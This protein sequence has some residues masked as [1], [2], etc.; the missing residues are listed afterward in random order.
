MRRWFRNLSALVAAG[1]VCVSVAMAATT[2]AATAKSSKAPVDV[3]AFDDAGGVGA[4]TTEWYGAEVAVDQLN[5]SGGWAGHKIVLK[6]CSTEAE[7]N[8]AS[9][10]AQ[11]A[12]A[13]KSSI[14]VIGS[15]ILSS[16]TD[17]I[18]QAAKLPMVGS[19]YI[20]EQDGASPISFPL[21]PS[22][23]GASGALDPFYKAGH[24]SITLVAG[25][26]GQASTEFVAGTNAIMQIGTGQQLAG[27]VLI[28]PTATD[29]STYATQ[30]NQ[31]P[32]IYTALNQP[33][34][35]AFMRA[36]FSAGGKANKVVC[37]ATACT[38]AFI[39]ALGSA[40]NGIHLG[41][42]AVPYSANTPAVKALLAATKKYVPSAPRDSELETGWSAIHLLTTALKGATKLS[43]SVVLSRMSH[44]KNASS[45][46]L[47]PPYTSAIP[48][49]GL[50][51]AAPHLYNHDYIYGIIK[52]GVQACVGTCKFVNPYTA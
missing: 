25:D 44:L 28:P 10:C 19:I 14:A 40:A 42:T 29:L 38:P 41:L 33:T 34:E 23:D 27:Q 26:F 46:G 18:L 15:S 4:P 5:A 50:G 2:A 43:R 24:Q 8:L 49:K 48:F 47:Y 37:I 9:S 11:R 36:Y 35:I 17:P 51:G 16:V 13:D 22:A 39:K 1:A 45:G 6:R 12:V 7:V 30:A 31:A 3:W 20:T 32:S 21:D 52:N